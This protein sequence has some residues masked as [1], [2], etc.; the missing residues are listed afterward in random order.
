MPDRG[1]RRLFAA[2]LPGQVRRDL[3]EPSLHDLD[4]ECQGQRRVTL[5]SALVV[6]FLDCW[7]LAP[8]EVIGMF[9]TDLRHAF[10][11]LR[12]DV[13]FTVT[14]V[15]TL[16]LGVGA[17]VSVFAVVNAVLLRPLPYVD[18]ERLVIIKHRDKPTG[19]TKE[20]IAVGDFVDLRAR[21]QAFESIAAYDSFQTVIHMPDETLDAAGLS[22]SPS[23]SPRSGCSRWPAAASTPPMPHRIPRRW[24]CSGTTSGRNGSAATRRSSDGRSRSDRPR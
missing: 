3:F 5:P 15:L 20:F 2:L 22:A 17:N 12:R 9:L 8:A 11:M 18:G 23:C 7:R 16:A 6:F 10:R 13:L 21:Q 24:R 4:I 1:L 19:I 14:A